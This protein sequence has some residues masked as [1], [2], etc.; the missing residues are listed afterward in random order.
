MKALGSSSLARFS[1]PHVFPCQEISP[2]KTML[3]RFSSGTVAAIWKPM[4]IKQARTARSEL[5]ARLSCLVSPTAAPAPPACALLS[6][7]VCFR[8]VQA[9]LQRNSTEMPFMISAPYGNRMCTLGVFVCSSAQV[10]KRA[11]L[12]SSPS[13]SSS[14]GANL[15]QAGFYFSCLPANR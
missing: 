11:A 14:H 12:L 5:A 9:S 8:G 10:P 1:A 13:Y 7:E 6:G 2:S 4:S 15:T 3:L